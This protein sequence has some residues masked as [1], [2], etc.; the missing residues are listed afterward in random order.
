MPEE[1]RRVWSKSPKQELDSEKLSLRCTTPPHSGTG[2]LGIATR[3]W[4][5]PRQ[6]IN[7]FRGHIRW[8]DYIHINDTISNVTIVT[9]KNDSKI[10]RINIDDRSFGKLYQRY[11]NSHSN[12]I[13]LVSYRRICKEIGDIWPF[14]TPICFSIACNHIHTYGYTSPEKEIY[15]WMVV[16]SVAALVWIT[17]LIWLTNRPGIC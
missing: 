6:Y 16:P 8:C 7:G 1:R 13:F 17:I 10:L 14:K 4:M 15:R 2:I 5:F 11:I 12:R 9:P 3:H